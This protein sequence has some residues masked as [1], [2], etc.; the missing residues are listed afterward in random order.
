MP[1][2]VMANQNQDTGPS[3]AARSVPVETEMKDIVNDQ[4]RVAITYFLM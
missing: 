1:T 3:S 4:G 2:A